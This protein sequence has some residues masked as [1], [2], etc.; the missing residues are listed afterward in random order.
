MGMEV[1]MFGKAAKENIRTYKKYDY[2][3]LCDVVCG[4]CQEATASPKKERKNKMIIK[5]EQFQEVCKKIL[6]S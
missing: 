6:G 4:Y 1:N 5:V 2:E 3:Q